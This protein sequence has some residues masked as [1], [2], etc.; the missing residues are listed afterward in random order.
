MENV[1]SLLD[2]VK[3][4]KGIESDYALAR[5]LNLPKQRISD[6]Y[7]GT[8][9]RV[10]DEFACLQ[11]AQALD[12][13]LA[14]VLAVVRIAAEKDEKRREAWKEYYKSIGGIAAEWAVALFVSVTLTV[15]T[16]TEAAQNQSD[17]KSEYQRIQIMRLSKAFR[18]A[19]EAAKRMLGIVALRVGNP[20]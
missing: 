12:R 1:K 16:P 10:P 2:A 11:I 20:A 3:A 14:D 4:A 5:A 13:P 9:N 17:M 18:R 7:K 15:T 19:L 8:G 6:Y